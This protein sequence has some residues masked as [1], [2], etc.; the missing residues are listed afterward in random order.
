MARSQGDPRVLFVLN[1]LLSFAFCS[2]V[3]WGLAFVGLGSFA[4]ERVGVVTAGLMLFN[5][6]VVL[7]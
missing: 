4:W 7:R 6:L 3:I 2:I 5:W 1:F